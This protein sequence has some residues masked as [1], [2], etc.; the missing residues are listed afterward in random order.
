MHSWKPSSKHLLCPPTLSFTSY[1]HSIIPVGAC[2]MASPITLPPLL[3]DRVLEGR[4]IASPSSILFTIPPEILHLIIGHVASHKSDL[5]SLALVNS[6]CR[7]LAR[8]YQFSNLHLDYGS[9]ALEI[10]AMLQK[11]A[12]Q[13]Y[14]SSDRMTVSPALGVCVRRLRVDAN[15]FEPRLMSLLPPDF[16]Q[17][18]EEIK[19]LRRIEATMS[20]SLNHLYWPTALLIIPTIPNLQ[21]LQL[22]RCT[23]KD[24]LLD[25]LIQLPIKNL[26]L[27]GDFPRMPNLQARRDL[28]P[29]GTLETLCIET[30]WSLDDFTFN[31]LV[32]NDSI[33]LDPSAFYK[34]L[35]ASCCSNLR[36]LEISHRRY[37]FLGKVDWVQE[38]PLS[39]YMKFPKLKTLNIGRM[40][41]LDPR[42]LTCL[43]PEG[44]TS[45]NIPYNDTSQF[46][47]DIGQICTLDTVL[48]H[49]TKA[50]GSTPTRFIETS[51]QIR[52][53][54]LF[55]AKD[56]FVRRVVQSAHRHGN[57]NSLSVR[58]AENDIS[59]ESLEKLSLLSSIEIL[60]LS[61]GH[62]GG[63]THNWFVDHNKVKRY[64]GR[65]PQ[66]RRLIITRDNY[67]HDSEI[68]N[69]VD[70]ERIYELCKPGS[71][72]WAE[73]ETRML[74]HALT[75]VH[76]LPM[77]EFLLIGQV[78]FT[79]K[80]IDGHREPFVTGSAWVGEREYDI[81][82]E[83]FK[84]YDRV[85]L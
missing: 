65:L 12:V 15:K 59:E 11:E 60:H 51:T 23:L 49:C 55:W 44:L 77:L 42:T 41:V 61:A 10:L 27:S 24:D 25:I 30:N 6:T 68:G 76:T 56:A 70:P 74:E 43:V 14:R 33:R 7:Q 26:E 5:A 52:L 32:D 71:A 38:P 19:R 29:L 35:L 17:E 73:H 1:T 45:L 4:Q 50:T 13:R 67:L 22:S 3:L 34:T 54:A 46:L 28:R 36:R 84:I 58:W 79:V 16:E 66:L 72:L 81:V 80:E 75:Y 39:F 64:L 63:W 69:I 9:A 57:L 83:E 40:T 2:E 78:I 21:S 31:K 20:E 82:V 8:S 53:L 47:P 62:P 18:G 37:D 48:L 85:M